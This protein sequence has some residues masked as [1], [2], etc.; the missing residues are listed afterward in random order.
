MKCWLPGDGEDAPWG[1]LSL[2]IAIDFAV[3]GL[4]VP[5]RRIEIAPD[6][7]GKPR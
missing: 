5:R 2:E 1:A 7:G 4:I 3:F 6:V